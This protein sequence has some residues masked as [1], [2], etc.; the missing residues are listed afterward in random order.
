MLLQPWLRDGAEDTQGAL[1][2]ATAQ[3]PG[4]FC[5]RG[6]TP[7]TLNLCLPCF[8]SSLDITFYSPFPKSAE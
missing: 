5:K 4:T 1:T 2:L 3:G 8:V 7:I 6:S